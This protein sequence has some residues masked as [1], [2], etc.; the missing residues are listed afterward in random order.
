MNKGIVGPNVLCE[1]GFGCPPGAMRRV[2]STDTVVQEHSWDYIKNLRV[3]APRMVHVSRYF[4][5][6]EVTDAAGVVSVVQ[7]ASKG[8][9]YHKSNKRVH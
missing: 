8:S 9:T 1:S 2:Q 3:P 7:R 6:E 4:F 5:T